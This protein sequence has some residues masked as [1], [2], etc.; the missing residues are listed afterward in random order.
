MKILLSNDDGIDASGIKIL[1]EML[2][3]LGYKVCIVAP[4]Y[5]QSATSHSITIHT[6]LIPR[7]KF[8]NGE[9]YG[10]YVNGTPSDA[11]K[12]GLSELYP[13]IDTVI[14][15]INLGNNAGPAIYYS[16]TVAAAFEGLVM[17]KRSFAFSFNSFNEYDFNGLGERFKPFLKKILEKCKKNILYNVNI[18]NTSTIKGI[19]VTR[20]FMGAFSDCYEKRAD[21]RNREYYWLKGVSYSKEAVIIKNKQIE[22]DLHVVEN[23]YISITPLQFDLTNYRQ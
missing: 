3:E 16:G 23:G 21:P 5:Q 1:F 14:S 6:P 4:E 12:L 13:D 9:F 18:P 8:I 7:K 19:K 22:A 15:G 17:Q 2:E 11:V 20:Q 10:I